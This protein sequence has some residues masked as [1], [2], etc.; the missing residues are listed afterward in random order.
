MNIV[1]VY[2]PEK[3]KILDYLLAPKIYLQFGALSRMFYDLE[4]DENTYRSY[5]RI[6]HRL[7]ENSAG[8]KL[9]W[10]DVPTKPS[11]FVLLFN[12][13]ISTTDSFDEIIS[14]FKS[15][16]T[17]ELLIK[18]LSYYD[19]DNNFSDLFFKCL[20][21]N[22][23]ATTEY[24]SSIDVP[25]D[26]KWQLAGFVSMP[27]LFKKKILELLEI[28]YEEVNK[29]YELNQDYINKYYKKMEDMVGQIDANKDDFF[30][31]HPP[32]NDLSPD[33][34]YSSIQFAVSL[35]SP[36]SIEYTTYSSNINVF[37][38]YDFEKMNLMD[39]AHAINQMDL[40]KSFSDNTR[41]GILSMVSKERLSA[42]DV[43]E[44]LN[45]S[46]SSITH[47]LDIL[48]RANMLNRKSQGKRQIFSI[49]K[50]S[51]K[52]AIYELQKYI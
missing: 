1:K 23:E 40:F 15:L 46:P 43:A 37:L 7:K 3:G 10:S 44:R 26:I 28:C 34:Y 9:F 27:E 18:L 30:N 39:N 6:F 49:K 8:I 32:L 17:T 41:Y 24:L 48:E 35:F 13:L 2:S 45:T 36:Y 5:N 52:H 47:H 21:K 11:F 4:L 20:S 12:D 42:G 25:V 14:A 22:K 29:E 19:T 50:N 33:L 31:N 51:I 16:D 38:G